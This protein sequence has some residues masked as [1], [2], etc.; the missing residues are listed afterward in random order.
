MDEDKTWRGRRGHN[1]NQSQSLAGRAGTGSGAGL[2]LD[3]CTSGPCRI[4]IPSGM[5]PVL[6]CSEV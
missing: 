2:H 1:R 4:I 5:E 6:S 3:A